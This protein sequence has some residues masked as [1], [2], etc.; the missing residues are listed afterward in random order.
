MRTPAAVVLTTALVA[1]VIASCAGTAAPT[2]SPSELATPTASPTAEPTTVASSSPTPGPTLI[3]YPGPSIPPGT[4]TLEIVATE[5]LKFDRTQLAAPAHTPF[6]IAFENRDLC[7]ANC[8][9][10][11]S[12]P[13][14]SIPHNVAIKLGD[15]LLFNPMPTI[16]APATADYYISEGLPA[17]TY[18]F[19]CIVHPVPMKG[20]LTIT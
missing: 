7:D 6:V 11:Y 14:P 5:H 17:G 3:P 20:T 4:L 2:A 16:F 15:E 1:T 13:L 18:Q 12:Y 8:Q 19:L 9:K 10:V